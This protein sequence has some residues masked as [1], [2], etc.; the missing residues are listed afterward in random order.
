MLLLEVL[1]ISV[2]PDD[3]LLEEQ[4]GS[5]CRPAHVRSHVAAPPAPSALAPEGALCMVLS[6]GLRACYDKGLGMAG[7]T[8]LGAKCLPSAGADRASITSRVPVLILTLHFGG[9]GLRG[10]V[11]QER[12]V[13]PGFVTS[14][15]DACT[16]SW[17]YHASR[18][19]PW[20]LAGM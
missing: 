1:L 16:A 9:G 14:E 11:R 18:A 15:L 13:P 2:L 20:P 12:P 6:W 4:Q 5:G 8:L 17:W 10:P 19:C 7:D 3:P